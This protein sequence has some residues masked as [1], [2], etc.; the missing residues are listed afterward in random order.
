VRTSNENPLPIRAAEIPKYQ[1]TRIGRG[2]SGSP[3]LPILFSKNASSAKRAK[4]KLTPSLSP[5]QQGCPGISRDS[6]GA[7][8]R[9]TPA[10]VGDCQDSSAPDN[11]STVFFRR[12]S[13]SG[14]P[15]QG[16]EKQ[17]IAK[18]RRP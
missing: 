15:M 3:S 12:H 5:C 16:Q 6:R 9:F 13:F 1:A 11:R 4:A 7:A 18:R 2:R 8:C 17:C 10:P 14:R